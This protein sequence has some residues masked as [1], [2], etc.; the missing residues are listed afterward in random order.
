MDQV[1][2]DLRTTED[3]P[4]SFPALKA[5]EGKEASE[6]KPFA[7]QDP[8][9]VVAHPFLD[10]SAKRAILAAWAS[11]A[12]AVEDLPHWR[13]VSEAGALV[14]LDVILDALLALDGSAL[15]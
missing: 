9:E 14:P 2:V 8:L 1:T 3:Q 5:R 15:H 13:K 10:T 12:C 4:A 7:I 11:D 6:G